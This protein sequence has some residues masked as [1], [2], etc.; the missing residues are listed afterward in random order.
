MN[1]PQAYSWSAVF[2]AH[3]E[4]SWDNLYRFAFSLV[5]NAP[6][7]EDLVQQTLVK[8]LSGLPAFFATNYQVEEPRQALELVQRVDATSIEKH[9]LNWM[10]KITKNAFIDER[11]KS[12]RRLSHK[13]LD[14]WDEAD[15]RQ[16]S[17]SSPAE[18]RLL[19]EKGTSLAEQEAEFFK[20]ALDD[21]WVERFEKL[22][23][24]QRSIIYL[25]AEEYSYK[26]IAQILDIPIGTVMSTLSRTVA[27]LK[28]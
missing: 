5:Q 14:D 2:L 26:E 8:A 17:H 19:S 27:K 10:M 25:A 6:E 1:T 3:T 11:Q 18:V 24:R 22:S 15:F 13:S 16:D 7:A 23:P 20:E 21:G 12:S 4:K 9:L 28:K